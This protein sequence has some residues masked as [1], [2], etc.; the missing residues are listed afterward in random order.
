[1]P[2]P[3]RP[4]PRETFCALI[5][6]VLALL[7]PTLAVA[8]SPTPST[9]STPRGDLGTLLYESDPAKRKAAVIRSTDVTPDHVAARYA[10]VYHVAPN[11]LLCIMDAREE[12]G[13][14]LLHDFAAGVTRP[15]SRFQGR[16]YTYPTRYE[17]R[18]ARTTDH[19]PSTRTARLPSAKTPVAGSVIFLGA[20]GETA[21]LLWMPETGP[22]L[23]GVRLPSRGEAERPQPRP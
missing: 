2:G 5:L 1:M 10:G 14:L 16:V 18:G 15:L 3:R 6:G 17:H 4:P 23:T 7:A 20:P 8:Q 22:A 19:T 11:H 13:S 12:L 21:R 9:P